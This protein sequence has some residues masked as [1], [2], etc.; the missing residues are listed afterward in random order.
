MISTIPGLPTDNL[1]KFFAIAGVVLLVASVTF[2]TNQVMETENSIAALEEETAL[3]KFDRDTLADDLAALQGDVRELE[4]EVNTGAG[5]AESK[6]HERAT[7][8]L[9][10]VSDMKRVHLDLSR[11]TAAVQA[12]S[13]TIQRLT[14]QRSWL[15]N[16]CLVGAGLGIMMMWSGFALWYFK[17]Q[18]L[19]DALLQR[20]LQRHIASSE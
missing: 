10:R 14:R 4:S 11:K 20:E 2:S 9:S 18:S 19:Q 12:K 3:L 15:I 6:L 5:A 8:L 13:Q 7:N 16:Q 17:A 1:Y